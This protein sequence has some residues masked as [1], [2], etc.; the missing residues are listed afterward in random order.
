MVYQFLG[1]GIRTFYELQR[2]AWFNLERLAVREEYRCLLKDEVRLEDYGT[3]FRGVDSSI[4]LEMLNRLICEN[5]LHFSKT[6]VASR[7]NKIKE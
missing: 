4:S 7:K 5:K 3:A 1:W 6:S 2:R